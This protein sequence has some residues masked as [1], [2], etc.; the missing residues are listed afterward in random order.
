MAVSWS[1]I[2]G[3]E[4]IV[5]QFTRAVER[6]RLAHA[7][8][9]VGPAGVGKRLFATEF[10]KALLCDRPPGPLAAC[11]ACP[12]CTQA[13][14]GTHPD[15]FTAQTPEDKFDLPV[16]AVREFFGQPGLKPAPRPR[17]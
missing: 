15:F 14:A 5:A 11:D 10:A 9:F 17:K 3:H 8:L 4:L 7:Y 16:E 13:A 12:S 1:H 2:R 6:G